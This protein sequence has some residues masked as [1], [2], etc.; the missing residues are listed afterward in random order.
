MRAT[1]VFGWWLLARREIPTYL[2][3][4]KW[5]VL[6][7]YITSIAKVMLP[8][9]RALETEGWLP[10]L[11][12]LRLGGSGVWLRPKQARMTMDILPLHPQEAYAG[13]SM[14]LVRKFD[15]FHLRLTVSGQ[16]H[17]CRE[18]SHEKIVR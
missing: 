5:L 18:S 2:S 9:L 1:K 8:H 4:S 10:R 11:C 12:D 7:T 16:N 15:S 13:P 3:T 17:G 6:L 14:I